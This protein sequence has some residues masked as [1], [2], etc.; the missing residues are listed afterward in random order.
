M[1]G[2]RPGSRGHRGPLRGRALRR[3]AGA[4]R[5]GHFVKTVHNGIE[6]ADMQ[7]IAEAYGLMRHGQGRAPADLAPVFARWNEGRL[8]SYLVEITAAV[9]AATDPLTGGPVLDVIL[10]SAG[11]KGTGRWTAVEALA[12]GQSASTIEAAVGA[13][14]WSSEIAVRA[15]GESILATR[16]SAVDL[17]DTDLEGALLAGRIIAYAQ[18]FRLL[19]AASDLHGW[20]TD[21]ARVAETWRAGCIIRSALLA[22]IAAAFRSGDLPEGQLFL[23]PAFAADL[24]ATLPAL[25]RTVA[26]AALAGHPVP[27]H[28]AALAFAD[29]MAQSRGTADLIQAQR[30]YFGR[31]GFVRRDTGA[32]H[33]HGPWA[34]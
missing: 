29:T 32:A 1:G 25:R 10:D 3:P 23:S 20:G 4:G 33:Q 30:D 2:S 11:Q 17:P 27:A 9:L 8:R 34:G 14:S 16:R 21:M 28:S 15:A 7:L 24:R 6:Y 18:G 26:A 13:R 19:Q 31:H 22:D 12:L 5:A